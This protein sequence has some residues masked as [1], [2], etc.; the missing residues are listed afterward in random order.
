MQGGEICRC[1]RENERGAWRYDKI[2][3]GTWLERSRAEIVAK[4]LAYVAEVTRDARS[5]TE[6]AFRVAFVPREM[7]SAHFRHLFTG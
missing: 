3:M 5:S 6:D 7:R 2:A 1:G 4:Q